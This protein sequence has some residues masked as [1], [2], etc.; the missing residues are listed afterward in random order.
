MLIERWK[1]CKKILPI[2]QEIKN[3]NKTNKNKRFIYCQNFNS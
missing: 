3:K 1:F 2:K